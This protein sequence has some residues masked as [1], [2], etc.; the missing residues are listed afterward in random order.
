MAKLKKFGYIKPTNKPYKPMD[1]PKQTLEGFYLSEDST[2]DSWTNAKKF[3]K[4]L[5]KSVLLKI[6]ASYSMKSS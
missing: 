5:S 3:Y 2:T 1:L 4:M 6:I